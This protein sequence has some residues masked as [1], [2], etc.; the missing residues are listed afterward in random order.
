MASPKRLRTTYQKKLGKELAAKL[1]DAQIKILENYYSNLTAAQKRKI[2]SDLANGKDN[3]ILEMANDMIQQNLEEEEENI[4]KG[5]DELLNEIRSAQKNIQTQ[6]KTNQLKQK[7]K[8]NRTKSAI[9]RSAKP[10]VKKEDLVDEKIN[11]RVLQILGLKENFDIDYGTYLT[12]LKER[13]AAARLSNSQIPIEDDQLI[14]SEYKRIKGKTGRFTIKTSTISPESILPKGRIS[15]AKITPRKFLPQAGETSAPSDLIQIIQILKRIESLL[16]QQIIFSNKREKYNRIQEEKLR[17]KT[18]ED[19]LEGVKTVAKKLVTAIE[20]VRKAFDAVMRFFQ[21]LLLGK[22]MIGIFNWVTNPKNRKALGAIGR[23][24]QDFWPALLAAFIAFGNPLGR[25]I[26]S[27][28]G[29][30]AAFTLKL[31]AKGIPKLLSAIA[32]SGL[33]NPLLLGAAAAGI[34]AYASTQRNKSNR[35]ELKKS[36]P[37]IVTPKETAKTGKTPKPSQ[38]YS[39]YGSQGGMGFAQGGYV[40][41]STGK[42]LTGFGPDTQLIAAQPGEIV[43]NKKTVDAVGAEALLSL[44]RIYGGPS[45]NKP[46]KGRLTAYNTGGIVGDYNPKMNDSDYNT[47]LAIT[48]I[49][50][51]DPQGRSDVAQSIYNRLYA[52]TNY[53]TNFNQTQNTIKNLITAPN[54]YEPTFGNPRD[55]KSITN[56]RTAAIAL[57]NSKKGRTMKWTLKDAEKQLLETERALRNPVYQERSRSHVGGRAYFL[58]TSQQDN[59]RKGDVLRDPKRNFFSPWYLEGT[60][61]DKERRN[62]PA[63]IPYYPDL[64]PDTKTQEPPPIIKKKES[65][66]VLNTIVNNLFFWKKKP[67]KYGPAFK[68]G[69]LIEES[70]GRDIPGATADRQLI[71]A[72]P[73]EYILPVDVVNRVGVSKLNDWV[74]DNDSNSNPA[75]IVKSSKINIPGPKDSFSSRSIT[76]PPEII[77][78]GGSGIIEKNGTGIPSFSIVCESASVMRSRQM[79]MYGITG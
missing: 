77:S 67:Q 31:T 57:V 55:W 75:N 72:Q 33:K 38:L 45:A 78:S 49:E 36:E 24:I 37:D 13:L 58:G 1:T 15:P 63:S 73:G 69:G 71:A 18:K 66:S 41:P 21:W 16:K 79:Q 28:V 52:A 34:G 23:F 17:R 25:F 76:L 64:I 59:M 60:Q 51:T 74:G 2:N 14:L 40:T 35:K 39:E 32:A 12:L 43:I 56:R 5:F 61:Y 9:T 42:K 22:I 65:S 70:T 47:L 20:P 19:R 27:I 53:G 3:E 10:P 62:K 7:R 30:I 46:K 26:T 44:N 50:D 29:K 48:S 8:S 4:P 54:Q 11:P 6:E 68:G